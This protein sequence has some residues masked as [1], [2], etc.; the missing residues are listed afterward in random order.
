M[1]NYRELLKDPR[2]QKKR[3]EVF[4]RDGWKCTE[5][6]TSTETLHVHHKR[7]TY[8][9]LPWEYEND[10]FLTLCEGCHQLEESL[11]SDNP[12]FAEYGDSARLT[13]ITMWKLAASLTYCSLNH[14]DLYCE[15]TDRLNA[16]TFSLPKG[17]EESK[18]FYNHLINPRRKG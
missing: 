7:Y 18:R 12:D 1:S 6:G 9:N 3:L 4:E 2:W 10:N 17:S 5:C 16:L 13:N 14:P 8:G 11:K 15:V